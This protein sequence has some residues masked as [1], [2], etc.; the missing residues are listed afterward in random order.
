MSFYANRLYVPRDLRSTPARRLRLLGLGV[1]LSIGYGLLAVGAAGLLPWASAGAAAPVAFVLPMGAAVLLS[2]VSTG[3]LMGARGVERVLILGSGPLARK[4]ANEIDGAPA[5][6]YRVVGFLADA[7]PGAR[8][9][10][11]APGPVVRPL[12]DVGPT[13]AE[14]GPDRL[15]VALSE[16]RGRLP[17]RELLASCAG[18]L[19]VEDGIE[20]YEQL[21]CK[22]AI[23]NL[24][25]STLIFDH[26]LQKSRWQ[27]ACRRFV[28]VAGAALGL[29]LT[30]PLFA[31]V[32]ALVKL[33]SPGPVFFVQERVGLHG[34]IFRLIKFRTMQGEPPKGDSVWRRDD[35]PRV[36]RVGRWLRDLHLDELPQFINV[37]KGDMDLVGPRPEM[38]CNVEAMTEHI[39]YYALRHAVRPGVTGWA[40]IR[41]GYAVTLPEVTEKVRYDLYYVKH[42]SV[43]L[44]LRIM[45]ATAHILL[46]GRPMA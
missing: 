30:A 42:M 1:L 16:R 4:I 28:S 7:D 10:A 33:G 19:R 39:P 43:W 17:V 2:V 41:Q 29:V 9:P 21:T 8:P 20:F 22:L 18:G 14:L 32:A 37:L 27:L 45:V 15:V 5:A 38:A 36:T 12:R 3:L 46:R 40:Q 31:V 11:A 34:R 23:E 26:V 13:I 35:V 24:S 44:D 6:P 25:P